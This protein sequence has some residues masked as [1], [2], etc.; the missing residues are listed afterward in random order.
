MLTETQRLRAVLEHID[1]MLEYTVKMPFAFMKCRKD[2]ETFTRH[3]LTLRA[4]GFGASIDRAWQAWIDKRYP[5]IQ[6]P[7]ARS[8]TEAV[9]LKYP[10]DEIQ[11]MEMYT[12]E[13]TLLVR[14]M[15]GEIESGLGASRQGEAE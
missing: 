5:E 13:M 6:D 8:V 3:M 15:K 14:A 10:H 7:I 11:R 2:A 12:E 1:S 4:K 9:L